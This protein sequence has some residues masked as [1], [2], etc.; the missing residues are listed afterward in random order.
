MLLSDIS[1]RDGTF[2]PSMDSLVHQGIG[3]IREP[4]SLELL[5]AAGATPVYR[6]FFYSSF[7]SQIHPCPHG[8]GGRGPNVAGHA[9]P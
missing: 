2:N 9:A 3:G 5:D 4:K 8:L 1:P 7:A 6:E